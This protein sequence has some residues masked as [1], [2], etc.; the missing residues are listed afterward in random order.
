MVIYKVLD[1]VF[2]TRSN[3]AVLRVLKEVKIG[4]S[5]REIAKQAGLSAPSA[6]ETLSTLENLNIVSRQRGG[7]EHFF[8]LNREH[9]LVKKIIVPNLNSEKKFVESLF[10]DIKK[11]LGEY[12]SSVILFGSSARREEKIESDLDICIV[13]RNLSAKKKLEKIITN[14]SF[15]LYKKHGVSLAPFYITENDFAKR[16]KTKTT[17]VTDII[18]EGK[19]LS[20]KTINELLN[21]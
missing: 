5:G 10:A 11:G 21:D 4:L 6:L 14:L 15:S 17:P 1:N 2:S 8:F 16:A 18:K 13:F 12:A 20:G 3:I 9:F 7:R 19:L